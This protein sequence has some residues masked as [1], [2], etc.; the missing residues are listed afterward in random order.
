MPEI[1]IEPTYVGKNEKLKFIVPKEL[2]S[3]SAGPAETIDRELAREFS[4]YLRGTF[5][6]FQDARKTKYGNENNKKTKTDP[7]FWEDFEAKAKEIIGAMTG[8]PRGAIKTKLK[9]SRGK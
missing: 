1:E 4:R 2:F 8:K 6:G 5:K 9:E 3:M 7:Q